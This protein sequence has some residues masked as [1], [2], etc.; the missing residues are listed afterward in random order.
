[1]NEV[2]KDV[3][4]LKSKCCYALMLSG[5][6]FVF[7][8]FT[9][10][11]CLPRVLSNQALDFDYIGVIVGILSVLITILVGW[12]VFSVIDLKNTAKKMEERNKH[13]E[14]IKRQMEAM[15]NSLQEQIFA[16]SNR[17]ALI[18]FQSMADFYLRQNDTSN[19]FYYTILSIAAAFKS[20]Q[21]ES[22]KYFIDMVHETEA[23]KLSFYEET[24][25]TML[26]IVYGC[27]NDHAELSKNLQKII[28]IINNAIII[29]KYEA[30]V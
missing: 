22:A 7:S 18:T 27:L 12:N 28:G 25:Q 23:E 9:L 5:C 29:P 15:Y 1:M 19:C 8:L 10:C 2:S 24:K 3:V 6:A 20:N 30:G 16:E 21:E 14:E 26:K 11:R 4:K 17:T 13:I